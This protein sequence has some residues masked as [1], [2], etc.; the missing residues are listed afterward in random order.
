MR[1][2]Y[3]QHRNLTICTN[4]VG[5]SLA[6]SNKVA[7][8]VTSPDHSEYAVGRVAARYAQPSYCRLVR[9]GLLE[10]L[11]NTRFLKV[12]VSYFYVK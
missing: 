7:C 1:G 12:L 3:C 8:G 9:L 11:R 4:S 6:T 10:G 5:G 2:Y